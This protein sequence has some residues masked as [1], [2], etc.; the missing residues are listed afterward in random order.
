M[1]REDL[2]GFVTYLRNKTARINS[3]TCTCIVELLV[4]LTEL[5]AN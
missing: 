2:K 3:T 5:S 4:P 1:D